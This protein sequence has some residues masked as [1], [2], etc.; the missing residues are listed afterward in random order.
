VRNSRRNDTQRDE[1]VRRRTTTRR[2]LRSGRSGEGPQWQL[3]ESRRADRRGSRQARR[4]GRAGG[5]NERS[6]GARGGVGRG[7][8]NAGVPSA[9]IRR[10]QIGSSIS[11]PRVGRASG[12]SDP[13]VAALAR[14]LE[15]AGGDQLNSP[16]ACS[17]CWVAW[18]RSSWQ[19]WTQASPQ[20][21]LQ[22]VSARRT[23][24]R[25]SSRWR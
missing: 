22:L 5:G 21:K 13:T 19:R 3:L 18:S 14:R 2:V 9:F 16:S 25:A 6:C 11:V 12:V 24:A 15:G 4:A 7:K 23:I 1:T 20:K 17:R 10:S 8:L